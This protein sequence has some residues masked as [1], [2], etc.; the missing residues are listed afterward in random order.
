[1]SASSLRPTLRT[2]LG[3]AR[4][5]GSAKEGVGHFIALRVSSVALALLAPWFV[6]SVASAARGGYGAIRDWL[7]EPT[8]AV[9][10][11]LFL[12]ASFHHTALGAQVVIEDYIHKA[13]SRALLLLAN[14][15]LA[16][17]FAAGG[18]YAV[19]RISFGS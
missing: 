8:T 9:L 4:G 13:S 10:T 14:G 11:I 17:A 2:P 6:L 18:A 16:A 1:M 7:A 3:R 19:L 5:L 15:L 12:V